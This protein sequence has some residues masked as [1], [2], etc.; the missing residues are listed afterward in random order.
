MLL[1][2][3]AGINVLAEVFQPYQHPSPADPGS[4]SVKRLLE[5][6]PLTG[7]SITENT[8]LHPL[9]KQLKLMARGIVYMALYAVP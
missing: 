1:A 9:V 8:F 7:V 2:M 5:V 3:P 4:A 6:M